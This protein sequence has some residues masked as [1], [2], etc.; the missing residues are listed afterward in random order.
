MNTR[1]M[2]V[3]VNN[4]VILLALIIIMISTISLPSNLFQNALSSTQPQPQELPD[5]SLTIQPSNES[6]TI[7]CITTPCEFPSPQPMPPESI[8]DKNNSES[9]PENVTQIPTDNPQNDPNNP[10]PCIS[11]CPP[12][13]ICI[14]MCKPLGQ[15]ETSVTEPEPS[16]E[17]KQQQTDSSIDSD[18]SLGDML[19]M[20]KE[21]EST[22][23]NNEDS[24]QPTS[25]TM[26][27]TL[28]PSS[29]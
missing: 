17:P 22:N 11:P 18:K 15:L 23:A 28:S 9:I 29:E 20:G 27:S 8:P 5:S 4:T 26:E 6:G 1:E 16:G 13:E 25:D 12:G 24:Q 19:S 21:E 7:Q 2:S 14:Q 3:N 10:E